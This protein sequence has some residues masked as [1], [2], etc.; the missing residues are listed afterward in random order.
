M[1]GIIFLGVLKALDKLWHWHRAF[2]FKHIALGLPGELIKNNADFLQNRSFI[3]RVGN[4]FSNTKP[5]LSSIP[6]GSLSGPNLF[7]I[8]VNNILKEPNI[9]LAISAG[10]SVMLRKHKHPHKVF[11]KF[12][13]YLDK[14][15]AW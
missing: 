13:N 6:Q 1:T 5:I 4:S 8:Y 3:F 11:S 2:L 14:I 9:D 7:S 12:Q 10:D 15:S